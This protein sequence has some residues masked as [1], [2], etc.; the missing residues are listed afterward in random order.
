MGRLRTG[1]YLALVHHPI[2]AITGAY[3]LNVLGFIPAALRA[4]MRL[5][6]SAVLG[7]FVSLIFA[8]VVTSL[9]LASVITRGLMHLGQRALQPATSG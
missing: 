6:P 5:R 3:L 2:F 8:T 7:L 1:P 4:V 9:L